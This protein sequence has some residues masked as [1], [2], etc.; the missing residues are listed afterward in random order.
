[1]SIPVRGNQKEKLSQGWGCTGKEGRAVINI[2]VGSNIYRGYPRHVDGRKFIDCNIT[3]NA[4]TTG[5]GGDQVAAGIPARKSRTP[6]KKTLLLSVGIIVFFLALALGLGL[7]LGLKHNGDSSEN[8][9]NT[10]PPLSWQ[11]DPT[12]YILSPQF[13]T[14]APNTIRNYTFNLTEIPNGAPDGVSRRMLLVNGKFP[15]PV[16]EANQG[17]QLIVQVHNNMTI[18]SAIHWHGQYQN[19][20]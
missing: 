18:P 12:D 6:G 10:K 3:M 19:G 9:E 11:R 7:G 5:E 20:Y 15:G 16:I 14:K 13:D 1:V 8:L 17:D 2:Q 4:K